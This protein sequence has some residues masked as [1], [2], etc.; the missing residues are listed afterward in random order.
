LEEAIMK[1]SEVARKALEREKALKA[2]IN[3]QIR[4][5]MENVVSS[6]L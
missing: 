4:K 6:R 3:E 1:T 5:A 2:T